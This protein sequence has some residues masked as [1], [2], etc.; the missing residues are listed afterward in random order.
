MAMEIVSFG[1]WR[2]VSAD[3]VLIWKRICD[4]D[5]PADLIPFDAPAL[6]G[7]LRGTRG[8]TR[9]WMKDVAFGLENDRAEVSMQGGFS[10]RHL[11]IGF[12]GNFERL[13]EPL[14]RFML[15]E[16]FACYS[17]ADGKFLT[18]W[19]KFKEPVI[20]KGYSAR[21]QRVLQRQNDEIRKREPDPKVRTKLMTMYMRSKEIHEEMARELAREKGRR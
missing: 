8:F 14:L 17:V 13:A 15:S 11:R 10:D 21:L 19:P 20:D 18:E 1:F 5:V 16:G 12:H 7:R 2:A 9:L 3:P 6:L 4:D